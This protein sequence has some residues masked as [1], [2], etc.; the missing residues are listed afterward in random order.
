[1][2]NSNKIKQ[3]TYLIV[4][5]LYVS[6]AGLSFA[7]SANNLAETAANQGLQKNINKMTHKPH[8][9]DGTY[10]DNLSSIMEQPPLTII[11][12]CMQS[13][14]AEFNLR[15]IT[16]NSHPKSIKHIVICKGVIQNRSNAKTAELF[17]SVYREDKTLIHDFHKRKMLLSGENK[18][19]LVWNPM[20]FAEQLSLNELYTIEASISVDGRN[21]YEKTSKITLTSINE[22]IGKVDKYPHSNKADHID[23]SEYKKGRFFTASC[24]ANNKF[25][26]TFDKCQ[27]MNIIKTGIDCVDLRFWH[28]DFERQRGVYDWSLMDKGIRWCEE[29]GIPVIISTITSTYPA[30]WQRTPEFQ[31]KTDGSLPPAGFTGPS[32]A[33][34][35]YEKAM[36][37]M[38]TAVMRRYHNRKIVVGWHFA[39]TQNDNAYG[40]LYDIPHW[41]LDKGDATPYISD[42]SD[43]FKVAFQDYLQ[44]RYSL[45]E[46]NALY[47]TEYKSFS[48]I[49]LPY[50]DWKSKWDRR[51]IWQ[52]FQKCKN[53]VYVDFVTKLYAKMRQ[54][55]PERLIYD[56]G[57]QAGSVDNILR[58]MQKYNIVYNL[59][60]FGQDKLEHRFQAYLAKRAEVPCIPETYGW[61][62]DGVVSQELQDSIIWQMLSVGCSGYL[63]MHAEY[64]KG[65]Y[66]GYF[67]TQK[68]LYNEIRDFKPVPADIGLL[69]SYATQ[70]S[71]TKTFLAGYYPHV[72]TKNNSSEKLHRTMAKS[73][74]AYEW[75]S[76]ESDLTHLPYTLIIDDNS[77][78]LSTNGIL[79]LKQFAENGGALCLFA[80]SGNYTPVKT[81]N[82]SNFALLNALGFPTQYLQKTNKKLE[83]KYTADNWNNL[84][85]I[86][87]KSLVEI[88]DKLS[89]NFKICATFDKKKPAI[90]EWQLGKGKVYFILGK[91]SWNSDNNHNLLHSIC[92][93]SDISERISINNGV[94][95]R[96]VLSQNNGSYLIALYNESPTSQ[97]IELNIIIPETDIN[98]YDMITHQNIK[99]TST[100][101]EKISFKL[102]I[103]SKRLH[104]VI[105]T[106]ETRSGEV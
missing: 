2:M 80:D 22:Y 78:I 102:K 43:H 57:L 81:E 52:D 34:A 94:K 6:F 14:P 84:I 42:Y 93:N 32:Y 67:E 87:L 92:I 86:Q 74:Y 29:L 47:N 83:I 15:E 51:A 17:Y 97:D 18:I 3:Q 21:I 75:F 91:F 60:I 54:I 73:G 98:I 19:L 82:E 37:D 26:S 53:K 50:P 77:T 89:D 20:T 41:T 48:D 9:P 40:P 39:S 8:K 106:P 1:M 105:I 66:D 104:I 46:L 58:A 88:Q 31:A 72:S 25:G 70:Y 30:L 90:V 76:D 85:G 59:S 55:D 33:S 56:W 64:G 79:R 38:A 13:A 12:D 23:M 36:L 28:A 24:Y 7:I 5:F 4:L 61:G 35:S 49:K 62:S 103:E 101:S 96:R 99:N 100:D 27:L 11:F 68:K 95:I 71:G 16:W 44:N 45:N 10:A 63:A 69:G 65:V